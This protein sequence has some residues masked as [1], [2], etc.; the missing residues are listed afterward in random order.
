MR[1]RG[2]CE[3]HNLSHLILIVLVLF[4][5]AIYVIREI[6]LSSSSTSTSPER[7]HHIEKFGIRNWLLW[8]LCNELSLETQVNQKSQQREHVLIWS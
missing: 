5:L 4:L 7:L 2:I 6:N 3:S 8:L 1:L